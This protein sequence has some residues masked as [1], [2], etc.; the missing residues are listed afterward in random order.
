MSFLVFLLVMQVLHFVCTWRLYVLAGQKAWQAAV[1]V[2]SAVILMRIVQRPWWWTILLYVPVV[3]NVMALVLWSDTAR[4]FGFRRVWEV[5]LTLA[6][7]GLFLAYVSYSGR[8]KYDARYREHRHALDSSIL[9]AIVF[10]TAAASLI[11][12]FTY[13]AY[14]IPT[15]SM[16]GS[17][18][19]GDFLFVNKMS[20]GTRIAMTPLSFPLVH[21]TIPVLKTRSYIKGVS[22][23]YLRL[24]ALRR[25][26]RGDIVVFNWP[27]DADEKPIDKRANYIKRCVALPGDTLELRRGELSIDGRPWVWS[28]RA[29]PQKEYRLT[30]PRTY[31]EPFRNL[32]R[33]EL[34]LSALDTDAAGNEVVQAFLSQE[35]LEKI[36][37]E[38]PG[39]TAERLVLEPGTPDAA[40]LFPAN[41]RYNRDNYGPLYVPKRGDR[42]S[43]T[44]DNLPQYRD[45]IVKYEGHTLD[46]TAQGDIRID[47]VP[48]RE[49]LV[50]QDYYFMMGDNRDNSLDS[51]YWGY[52][53]ADH[54]VGSPAMIWLSIAPDDGTGTPLFKRIRTE[55]V[56]SFPQGEKGALRS[57][58]WPIVL[59]GCALYGAYRW[60]WKKRKKNAAQS[61]DK[62]KKS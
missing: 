11:K 16:E 59:G 19:V 58:F 6:S 22:L 62:A 32:L 3:G 12:A 45:I 56:F 53:P 10:A 33:M 49:Y 14:T 21:D 25:I 8:A 41:A 26:K 55:R 29:R 15:S 57:Y 13:E 47:G 60:G 36:R 4:A 30:F 51:R 38:F 18:M 5:V 20:Y 23:P 48:T 50:E 31:Y 27:G 7:A 54:I 24:P 44:R 52:V 42:I 61:H 35:N 37:A 39:V 43:L 17:M 46:T 9:G 1:P 2:Y 28:E 40:P 34:E